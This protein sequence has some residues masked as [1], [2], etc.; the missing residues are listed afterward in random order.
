MARLTVPKYGGKCFIGDRIYYYR[1][2]DINDA[3]EIAEIYKQTKIDKS[4]YMDRLD[5]LSPESFGRKGGMFVVLDKQ[6]IED[7]IV[8]EHNFW[9]VFRTEKGVLAGSFWFS[10][11]NENYADTK[12]EHMPHT[13]YPREIAVSSEYGGKNLAKVMYYTIAIAML[14]ASY[15]MG[16][17][18]LY[19]VVGYDI[20]NG[21]VSLDMVNMPSKLSIEAIG[22]EFAERLPVKEVMLDGITVYIEPQM[23]LFY[24][25]KLRKCCEALF[26]KWEI[27][28]TED[29]AL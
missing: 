14:R 28:V 6:G 2:A 20:G 17:A 3:A 23:Y 19:K 5:P 25:D 4:N 13:V 8:K 16:A 10:L 1:K 21:R 12:Y 9:A 22:A 24:Y 29:D 15:N 18:D 26:S 27:D 7:E 11:E